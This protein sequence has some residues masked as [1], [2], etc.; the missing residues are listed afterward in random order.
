V[1]SGCGI[2]NPPTCPRGALDYA[3]NAG[4]GDG[5]KGL[6]L[7]APYPAFPDAWI[8]PN[9]TI[10]PLTPF[11]NVT[12]PPVARSPRKSLTVGTGVPDGD[13]YTILVG[14][15]NFNRQRMSDPTQQDEDNG[16]IAGYSWDTIRWGYGIPLADRLDMSDFD[17]RFGSSHNLIAQFLFCDGSVKSINYGVDLVVFQGACR[18]EDGRAPDESAY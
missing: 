13:S 4:V 8:E 17:T 5:P 3:G 16:Y 14:E 9:G 2:T 12:D 11:D 18:R 10:V 6:Q 15:R 1:G 7:Y